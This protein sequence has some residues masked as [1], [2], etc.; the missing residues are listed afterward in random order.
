MVGGRRSD[1]ALPLAW[2]AGILLFWVVVAVIASFRDG[3]DGDGVADQFPD[4]RGPR[5][6]LNYVTVESDA[7]QVDAVLSVVFPAEWL[8][9]L[10]WEDN[11]DPLFSCDLGGSCQRIGNLGD[12]ALK[13]ELRE[14]SRVLVQESVPLEQVS[15]GP[16]PVPASI[17]VVGTPSHFPQDSYRSEMLTVWFRDARGVRS[18]LEDL[19]L[20]LPQA[21]DGAWRLRFN[22][23]DADGFGDYTANVER[24]MGRGFELGDRVVVARKSHVR[25]L[26]YAVAAAPVLDRKS[27]V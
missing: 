11:G 9:S 16:V 12:A 6:A 10:R 18:D 27:V 26:I 25:I 8:A 17:P 19:D 2:F 21:H 7:R 14:G 4:P 24:V 5:A 1:A 22:L 23:D 15:V 3:G 20:F 13:I